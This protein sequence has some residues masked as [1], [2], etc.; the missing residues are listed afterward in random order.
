MHWTLALISFVVTDLFVALAIQ[1]KITGNVR[2]AGLLIGG[3]WLA[4]QGYFV[5]TG[6][7]MPLTMFLVCDALIIAYLLRAR[8]DWTDDAIL[9]I[10]LPMIISYFL[11]EDAT[12]HWW[13]LWVGTLCQMILVYPWL[14][15]SKITGSQ[16]HGPIRELPDGVS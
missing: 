14:K 6:D 4:G 7:E 8:T 16:Q 3:V 1:W 5:A 2:V 12:F 9:A 11:A 15:F 10:Y 13:F